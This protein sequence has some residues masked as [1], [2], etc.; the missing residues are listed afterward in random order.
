MVW[1]LSL[2]LKVARS[3]QASAVRGSALGIHS[4]AQWP[5]RTGV[6]GRVL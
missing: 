5:G 1:P 6:G 4:N 3:S 2:V